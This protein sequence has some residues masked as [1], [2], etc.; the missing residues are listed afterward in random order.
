VK[1]RPSD[2]GARV[3]VDALRNVTG[4]P[5]AVREFK[6]AL[7]ST[8]V[9]DANVLGVSTLAGIAVE[10]AIQ[11]GG[12][13]GG[14]LAGITNAPVPLSLLGP[15]ADPV[16][17]LFPGVFNNT[18]T[19]ASGVCQLDEPLVLLPGEFLD[20]S[21]SHRQVIPDPIDAVFAL[22][23]TVLERAP[24]GDRALPY[25]APYVA[26]PLALL[27]TA[28][29]VKRASTEKDLV[30][31][32]GEVLR[33]RRITGRLGVLVAYADPTGVSAFNVSDVVSDPYAQVNLDVMA[34]RSSLGFVV[35]K[36]SVAWAAVFPSPYYSL[37]CPHE[38]P[39]GG[40]YLV[41]LRLTPSA[42]PNTVSQLQPAMCLVGYR[43]VQG[44]R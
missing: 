40:Y 29:D 22:S 27:S 39:P 30:N 38:V 32:T 12:A 35:V 43:D 8:R 18:P 31:A 24:R 17:E 19:T 16:A 2:T 14:T 20:V 13:G 9:L 25:F 5:I 10:A 42:D 1:L 33:V 36:Q 3:N 7:S 4:R 23:G 34:M 41:S 26:E 21:L 11:L 28:T 37:E 6:W 44:V 15:C